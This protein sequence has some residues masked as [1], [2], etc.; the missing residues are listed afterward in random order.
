MKLVAGFGCRQGCPADRLGSLLIDT[1]ARFNLQGADL[2]GIAS[3]D[4]KRDEPGLLELAEQ[5]QLPLHFFS[6][7]QLKPFEPQ[8][9]HRSA[10]A[11]THSGCHGVAESAA[12]ALAQQLSDRPVTLQVTR[13]KNTQATLALAQV[14]RNPR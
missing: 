6:A 14:A 7:E 1:L 4:I 2:I 3:L 11:F 9:S 10:L 8:L 12:L 13:Q 5:L